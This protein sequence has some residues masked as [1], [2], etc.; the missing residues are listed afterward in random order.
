M[1][2]ASD[3]PTLERDCPRPGEQAPRHFRRTRQATTD[4]YSA[5]TYR[6]G[7]DG[8]RQ[9]APWGIRCANSCPSAFP[10]PSPRPTRTSTFPSRV[11]QHCRSIL[12][13]RAPLIDGGETPL[14]AVYHLGTY[15]SETAPITPHQESPG[16]HQGISFRC[17]NNPVPPQSLSA[18]LATTALPPSPHRPRY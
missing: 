2:T 13:S 8:H 3:N 16:A 4:P 17:H 9:V 18:S 15:R 14:L 5:I 12:R 11:C 10:R 7:G 1:T 6:A